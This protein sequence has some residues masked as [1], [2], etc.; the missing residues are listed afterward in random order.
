MELLA[1]YFQLSIA[2]DLAFS[3]SSLKTDL[4]LAFAIRG[5][6][7]EFNSETLNEF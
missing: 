7:K 6:L 2:D 4:I 1:E 3:K 5:M